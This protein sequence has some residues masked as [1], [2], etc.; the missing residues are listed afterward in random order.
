MLC[1]A[2]VIATAAPSV[3]LSVLSQGPKATEPLTFQSLHSDWAV[4][5]DG[6]ECEW[7]PDGT[8]PQAHLCGDVSVQI[9][10]VKDVED[11][12]NSLRRAVL[13]G[14]MVSAEHDVIMDAGDAS[15]MVLPNYSVIAMSLRNGSEEFQI[16]LHGHPDDLIPLAQQTWDAISEEPMPIDLEGT[17]DFSPSQVPQP[18]MPVY[19]A[20]EESQA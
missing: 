9:N 16:L 11:S 12:D 5:V 1:A 20:L 6:V 7:D 15:M 3:V 13:S 4:P 18:G 19:A 8:M 2:L 10:S 14:L 17:L